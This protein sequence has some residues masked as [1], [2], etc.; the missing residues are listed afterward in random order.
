MI[1]IRFIV[2]AALLSC[3][4][5]AGYAT[6]TI[7]ADQVG[8]YTGTYITKTY[9]F[10]TGVVK[11][12]KLPMEIVL[13]SDDSYTVSTGGSLVAEGTGFFGPEFG[14]LP[15]ASPPR[16][17]Q[18]TLHFKGGKIKGQYSQTVATTSGSFTEGKISLKKTTP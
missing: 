16:V 17:L 13:N 5:A 6:T 1:R 3:M 7:S 10:P 18:I 2:L 14:S 9:S 15:L 12:L 8:T 11:P 4:L